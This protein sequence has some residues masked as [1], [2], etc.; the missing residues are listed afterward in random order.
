MVRRTQF[1]W[2]IAALVLAG[3][4]YKIYSDWRAAYTVSRR[5]DGQAISQV[6][7]ATFSGATALKVAT[8]SGTA[9]GVA[10]DSRGFGFLNSDRVMK[11]PYTVDYFVDLSGV[12]A[13]QMI[14]DEAGQTLVIKVPDVTV[15]PVNVDESR[16]TL[17]ETRGIFVTRKASE[18]LALDASRQ[19]EAQ[20]Q[21]KALSPVY[22]GKARDSARQK[23]AQLLA[24]PLKAKGVPVK[25]V[26]I[27]FPSDKP[28]SG[29]QWDVSR[30]IEEVLN[31]SR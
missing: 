25:Q 15:A 1:L 4:G 31:D 20:A 23:L 10:S 13:R 21:T 9:Q 16:P 17:V 3:I 11:A 6:V 19:A 28:K 7:T 12:S 8:L 14:W 27:V 26:R 2:L 18:K 24:A 29:E 5:D 30:S 22:M